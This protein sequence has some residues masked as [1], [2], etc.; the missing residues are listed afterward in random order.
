MQYDKCSDEEI[1][2]F[3]Q[4]RG[5]HPFGV[6]RK[7]WIEALEIEDQ[8][9]TFPLFKL[10]SELRNIVYAFSLAPDPRAVLIGNRSVIL[11]S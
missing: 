10:P 6:D 11:R 4:Q 9:A 2:Q 5:I 8:Q 7:T 1:E 3:A